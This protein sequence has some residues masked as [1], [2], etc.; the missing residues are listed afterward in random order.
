LC[1]RILFN[2]I[3]GFFYDDRESVYRSSKN[4]YPINLETAD[5]GTFV[6]TGPISGKDICFENNAGYLVQIRKKE[7]VF[8]TDIV[9]VRL[10][11]GN[12]VAHENQV[13]YKIDEYHAMLM[14]PYFKTLPGH[15]LM[16]ND[17]NLK[18]SVNGV[19]RDGFYIEA[20][21]ES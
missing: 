11:N 14:I 1:G 4:K 2:S 9:V 10:P 19:E 12:I 6:L 5:F 18:F 13:F 3:K 17:F 21:D 7:G 20:E 16:E 15:D 8:G